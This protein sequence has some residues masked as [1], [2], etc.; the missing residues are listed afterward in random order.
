MEIF[1]NINYKEQLETS[2]IEKISFIREEFIH[3]FSQK[4]TYSTTD[5]KLALDLLN[6]LSKLVQSPTC[7]DYLAE[8]LEKLEESFPTLF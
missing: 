2:I 4:S 7:L 6:Q 5:H 3:L 1:Y 8:T